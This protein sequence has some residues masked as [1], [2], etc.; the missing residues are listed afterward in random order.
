LAEALAL[1]PKYTKFLKDLLSDKEKLLGLA[2]TSLTENCSAV[3]LKKLPEKL[4]DPG[5]FL[6]PCDFHGLESCMALS[7]LGASINLM[8]LSV[9]KKLSLPDLTPTRMTLELA[10]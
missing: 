1:M 10:T 5:R 6:I 8:P 9:W 2:N 7:N 4:G 3:L